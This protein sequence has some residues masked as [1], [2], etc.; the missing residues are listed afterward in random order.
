MNQERFFVIRIL[1][2]QII[3]DQIINHLY[4]FFSIICP[5]QPMVFAIPLKTNLI[6][7]NELNLIKQVK[8]SIENSF[9]CKVL[10]GIADTL[11]AADIASKKGVLVPKGKTSKFLSQLPIEVLP[12][13]NIVLLMK[14]L[15]VISLKDFL[16]LND[17][18]IIEYLE[19]TGKYCL[20]LVK[21][22]IKPS[23]YLQAPFEYCCEFVAEF[24][25]DYLDQL[26]SIADQ[27]FNKLLTT[28]TKNN[29]VTYE[30]SVEIL[31]ENND[32]L[33]FNWISYF[34]FNQLIFKERLLWQF[35]SLKINSPVCY[36]KLLA[37][38]PI[39]PI[40]VKT[41]LFEPHQ[42][43]SETKIKAFEQLISLHLTPSIFNASYFPERHP[44]EMIKIQPATFNYF[45]KLTNPLK[46]SIDTQEVLPWPG[47]M[48]SPLP[49]IVCL[50]PTPIDLK[51]KV[52]KPIFVNKFGILSSQ[53]KFIQFKRTLYDVTFYSSPWTNNQKW[54]AL[55]E[56]RRCVFLQI[57][58]SNQ[59]GMLISFKNNNW[60]LEGIFD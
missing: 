45:H 43:N 56:K 33:T 39:D 4:K 36:I 14:S 50:N 16:T 40:K 35:Q 3:Q 8:T 53:P 32:K 27:L 47:K 48:P 19:H 5:I 20:D 24:P 22:Y 6:Y 30:L 49:A 44:A 28:L 21:G 11:F 18:A 12:D 52:Y 46:S 58:T 2:T 10:I 9:K 51:D 7:K 59:I 41:S 15:G 29:L 55:S 38:K 25:I 13:K 37:P 23:I 57:L 31:L 60:Y 34:P 26:F 54:W 42:I 17:S 1:S